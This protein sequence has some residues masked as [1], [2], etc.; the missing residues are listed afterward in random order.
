MVVFMKNQQTSLALVSEIKKKL[1]P[2]YPDPQLRQQYAWWTVQAITG[3]TQTDLISNHELELTEEQENKLFHWL[4]ALINA[5]MPIQ[6]L[7]GSVPFNGL[8]ILVKEPVLIP[9]PETEEWTLNL[10]E[11]LKQLENKNLHILD[12]CTGTGCI[13]LALAKALPE[14]SVLATD[15]SEQALELAEK[16]A[17]HNK[18]ENVT[19]MLS[20]L[21]EDILIEHRFDLIVCNPP[22]IAPE[23]WNTLDRS[24]TAWEDKRAL[25]AADDGLA[26]IKKIIT[27]APAYLK[28]NSEIA[29]KQLPQLML[30]IGHAQADTVV[31]LMRKAG[32]THVTAHQD[33]EHKN[34]VVSGRVDHV[35]TTATTP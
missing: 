14:A 5:H 19:F 33:L 7:I 20:D 9:R 24:V 27:T 30:E 1:L 25:V 13:A 29:H 18:I 11:Q 34:R 32:Y 2:I 4:D 15:I 10:I 12:L 17:Q 6:Y 26:L 16:N 22:Y 31:A 3:R 35:A 8:E 28:E 23:E 21:F